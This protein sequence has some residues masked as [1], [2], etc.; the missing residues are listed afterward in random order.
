MSEDCKK[1]FAMFAEAE[2]KDSSPLYHALS[3]SIAEDEVIL[4]VAALA[5]PGQPVPNLLFAAVQYLLGEGASHRLREFYASFVDSPAEPSKAFLAFRDFVLNHREEIVS[6]LESRLVQ[7]N[8]VRRCAYIFPAF[9]LAAGRFESRPLALVEIGTSAG[10]NLLWDRYRY[11]YGGSATYGDSSSEV[12]ITSC[13]HGNIPPTLSA[14][15]PE[16]SHRIG[17]DLNVVDTSNADQ[18]AWLR[19]LVWPEHS[20]RRRLLDA[21]VKQRSTMALDLRVGDGFSQ[22]EQ[23]AEELP[24][25][26]L[27]CIYHTHVANQISAKERENFLHV[28]DRIGARRDAVHLFNNIHP[29]L[30][31]TAYRDGNRTD[32]PLARADGHAQRIEWLP[33]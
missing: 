4:E 33:E 19:A 28:L 14:P 16:V 11:S 5:R 27:L 31:L 7:T 15:L 2:C 24:P 13:F 22:V 25:E 8:E 20:E 12:L 1:A 9:S 10:L 17:L 21:A 6:L 26:S 29:H 3:R 32:L 30:H 23:I 18:A